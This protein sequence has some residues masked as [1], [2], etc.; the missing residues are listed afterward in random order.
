[1]IRILY[2]KG[3]IQ[4][5]FILTQTYLHNCK[6]T[7]YHQKVRVKQTAVCGYIFFTKIYHPF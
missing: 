3:T 5:V 6:A 7:K 1:M 2:N 4:N